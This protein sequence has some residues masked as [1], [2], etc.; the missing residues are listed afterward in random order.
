MK[1]VL[2]IP[3]KTAYLA[4][5]AVVKDGDREDVTTGVIRL[6]D[7]Y[8]A[9]MLYKIMECETN[10]DEA[11]K[12]LLRINAVLTDNTLSDKGKLQFIQ[13]ALK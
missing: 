1:I 11:A 5:T 8:Q 4:M 6:S 9:A 7:I 2:D 10:R 12:K 13:G 3:E